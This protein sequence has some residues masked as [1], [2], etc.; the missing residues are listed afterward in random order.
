MMAYF[1]LSVASALFGTFLW[2]GGNTLW[3][4]YKQRSLSEFWRPFKEEKTRIIFTEYIP[5]ESNGQSLQIAEEA[6]DSL[7]THGMAHALRHVIKHCYEFIGIDPDKLFVYGD[8]RSS[9][10]NADV[11][12]LG[13]NKCNKFSNSIYSQKDELIPY[14]VKGDPL[15]LVIGDKQ[16]IPNV[17]G[18][19]A[20]LDYAI[21]VRTVIGNG[22]SRHAIIM[23]GCKMYGTHGAAE[24]ATD[25]QLIDDVKRHVSNISNVAFAIKVHVVNDEVDNYTLLRDE[26]GDPYISEI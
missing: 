6:G 8:K 20:S 22:N 10:S 25:S 18:G 2:K 14:E 23:G 24:A 3:L 1:A 12:C 26:N 17:D 19:E 11:I 7:M 13:S 4:W 16:Y 9:P 15:R 21:V 5:S